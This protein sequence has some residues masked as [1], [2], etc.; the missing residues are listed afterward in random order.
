MSLDKSI[1]HQ[2]PD[3]NEE[4]K[5]DYLFP[6]AV[7]VSRKG[8]ETTERWAKEIMHYMDNVS[9]DKKEN[10]V[11]FKKVK[12]TLPGRKVEVFN[13]TEYYKFNKLR[14]C[15]K[16]F[17]VNEQYVGNASSLHFLV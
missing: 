1:L 8:K 4:V 9:Y 7:G 13:D 2:V 11:P 16:F 12:R 14:D 15:A 17:N 3:E 10:L 5:F 6:H